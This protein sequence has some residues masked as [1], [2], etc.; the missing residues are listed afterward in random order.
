MNN[1]KKPSVAIA[2]AIIG[3]LALVAVPVVSRLVDIFLPVPSPATSAQTSE[4]ASFTIS[5]QPSPIA[6]SI[7]QIQVTNTQVPSQPTTEPVATQNSNL[8]HNE[9]ASPET[10]S[11]IVGGDPA[12]WTQKS[13]VV[14]VYANKDHNT[15]MRHPGD[16]MILTY[17][18]GFDE[19]DADDCQIIISPVNSQEKY[20]KCSSGTNAWV[21]ADQVG[22]HLIDYTGYFP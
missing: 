5:T 22:L 8:L 3:A 1:E 6:T 12:Y 21:E 20:V 10:L 14:W 13:S 18:A 7:P 19:H 9:S 2:I 17:W 11:R 16:N 4:I 15:L